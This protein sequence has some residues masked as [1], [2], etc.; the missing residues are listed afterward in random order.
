MFFIIPICICKNSVRKI[1]G[2]QIMLTPSIKVI[3]FSK[4]LSF[5]L[6]VVL[7]HA[8]WANLINR[9]NGVVNRCHV[10]VSPQMDRINIQPCVLNFT[11]S[12][13]GI[14]LSELGMDHD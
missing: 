13:E 8:K 3:P 4:Y 11:V 7:V 2:N 9:T 10:V 1:L 12:K 5:H 14:K 6:G